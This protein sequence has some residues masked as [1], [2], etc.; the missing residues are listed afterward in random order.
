MD[1]A[2]RKNPLETDGRNPLPEHLAAR[3]RAL[4]EAAAELER[5]TDQLFGAEG[6]GRDC[7]IASEDPIDGLAPDVVPHEALSHKDAQVH[8]HHT[9]APVSRHEH[10]HHLLQVGDLS[11]G[12]RMYDEDAPFF[13]AK[14]REVEVIHSLSISVHAGEIVAVVGA[15]GSGKTLLADAVLGLFEPNATV[16]GRVWFDGA[17]QDAASLSALRGH[18]I[19]LV[20]QS[21]NNLD[22]LMKVGRQ[23]EGFAR[24]HESR[25]AS[26]SARELFERYDRPRTRREV[27]ARAVGEAWRAAFFVLRAHGRPARHRGRRATPGLDLIWPCARSTTSAPSPTRAAAYAYHARHQLALRGPTAWRVR[28]GTVVEERCE[29]RVSDLL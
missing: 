27:S 26:S 16:R 15:S 17:Q 6:A 21:V 4:Y 2:N 18:G 1:E 28:D 22:P 24:A 11:V 13:R 14:Q 5:L 29:L 3:E 20:P 23:V 7:A 8:H 12:F 19:S 25:R 10:G 9:H